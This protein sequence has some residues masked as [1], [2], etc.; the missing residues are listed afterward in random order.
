M[1]EHLA[2]HFVELPLK[3][4]A[5][6]C[7]RVRGC[8]MTLP[9]VGNGVAGRRNGVARVCKDETGRCHDVTPV[10]FAITTRCYGIA[11]CRNGLTPRCYGVTG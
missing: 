9:R 5:S 10:R 8:G 6:E 1:G 4:L 11:R 3:R 7:T 2:K